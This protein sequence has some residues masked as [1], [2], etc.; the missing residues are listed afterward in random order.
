MQKKRL[1][2]LIHIARNELG[3]DEDTYR[4]M[5]QG[6]TGKAST[7]GMDTTQLNCVRKRRLSTVWQILKFLRE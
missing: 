1:I 7:K 2:Q 5:L 4:Q 6:L 3:M